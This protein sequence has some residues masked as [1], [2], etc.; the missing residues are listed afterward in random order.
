[1][2]VF[3]SPFG[4]IALRDQ[5]ITERVME[6]LVTRSGA[7]VIIDGPTGRAITGA[8]LVAA[9][10][11][12]AGGLAARGIGPGTV[13]GLMAPNMPE[14]VS[15]F[16]GI[17]YAGATVTTINPTYTA[18]EVRHQLQDAGAHLLIT[19]PDFL[20]IAQDALTG[21]AVEEIVVIGEADGATPLADL[22]GAP[23]SA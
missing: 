13:I 14:F 17:V 6:G 11:S 20:S 2:T 22:M 4:D 19:I 7:T 1:M 18:Q 21:T 10:Q 3:S 5:T 8:D 9:I 15:C 16:H 23:L 12:L